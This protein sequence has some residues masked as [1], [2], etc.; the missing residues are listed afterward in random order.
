MEELREANEEAPRLVDRIDVILTVT[1]DDESTYQEVLP[2]DLALPSKAGGSVTADQAQVVSVSKTADISDLSDVLMDAYF[3]HDEYG[4]TYDRQQDECYDNVAVHLTDLFAGTEAALER[5]IRDK[6]RDGIEH[7]VPRNTT[8]TITIAREEDD[9]RVSLTI[10]PLRKEAT[11]AGP[12][13]T[14]A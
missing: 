1:R 10:T 13:T 12:T 7:E 8:V 11:A 6:V 2:V 5:I 9:T 4:D 14:E 3:I